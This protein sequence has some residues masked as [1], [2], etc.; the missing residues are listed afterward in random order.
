MR[1]FL[2]VEDD[3]VL[4]SASEE[5]RHPAI[6]EPAVDAFLLKTSI[7]RLVPL[8]RRLVGLDEPPD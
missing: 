5:V 8:A 4:F 3:D 2:V 1:V 6:D 7:D